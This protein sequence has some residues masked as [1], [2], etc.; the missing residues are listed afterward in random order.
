M[1]ELGTR[2]ARFGGGGCSR[3]KEGG[4]RS[5]SLGCWVRVRWKCQKRERERERE[6]ILRLLLG[7]SLFMY[8]CVCVCVRERE[9]ERKTQT[10]RQ[11]DR[12]T[13]MRRKHL[14]VYVC[15][16]IFFCEWLSPPPLWCWRARSH[17]ALDN[18]VISVCCAHPAGPEHRRPSTTLLV[19]LSFGGIV[20]TLLSPP[21]PLFPFLLYQ[22]GQGP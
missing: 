1:R 6:K 2:R 10:D 11:T 12:Q 14:L 16:H 7:L 8:A 9:R 19:G 4:R 3:G 13:D 5:S 22:H 21:P 15:T 17:I 20:I 18:P